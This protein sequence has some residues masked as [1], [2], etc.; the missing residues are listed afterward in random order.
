MIKVPELVAQRVLAP[1]VIRPCAE[2]DAPVPVPC[3]KHGVSDVSF[4]SLRKKCGGMSVSEAKRLSELEAEQGRSEPWASVED[5]TKR[6][7]VAKDSVYKKGGPGAC[8]RTR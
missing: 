5:V 1:G 3:R 6:I 7:G 4:Y 2:A 8:R